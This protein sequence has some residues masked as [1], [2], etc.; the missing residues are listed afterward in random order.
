M[1]QMTIECDECGF[2]VNPA[3]EVRCPCGHT[4]LDPGAPGGVP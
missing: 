1:A 3:K 2:L 4:D